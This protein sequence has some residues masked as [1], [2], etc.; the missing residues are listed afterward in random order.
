MRSGGSNLDQIRD[1]TYSSLNSPYPTDMALRLHGIIE[2]GMSPSFVL[3]PRPWPRIEGSGSGRITVQ[4]GFAHH[5]TSVLVHRS[6]SSK[7]LGSHQCRRVRGVRYPRTGYIKLLT[8]EIFMKTE[9]SGSLVTYSIRWKP[10]YYC[11][12]LFSMVSRSLSKKPCL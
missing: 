7:I 3:A 11:H 12:D 8:P 5:S 10:F 1:F 4:R 6:S 2:C 9:R